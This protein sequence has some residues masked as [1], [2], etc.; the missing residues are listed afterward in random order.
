MSL[1]GTKVEP[2]FNDIGLYDTFAPVCC[3]RMGGWLCGL[4]K[5]DKGADRK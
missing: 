5:Y 4:R 3:V 1:K 2:G